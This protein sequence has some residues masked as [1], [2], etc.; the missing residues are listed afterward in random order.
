MEEFMPLEMLKNNFKTKI[1][2]LEISDKSG[3]VALYQAE[4]SFG[5]MTLIV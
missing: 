3:H 1:Y 5:Q 4:T 2:R